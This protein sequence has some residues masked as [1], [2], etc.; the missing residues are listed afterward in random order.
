MG[1]LWQ[2]H[3]KQVIVRGRLPTSKAGA[4]LRWDFTRAG[5]ED[6]GLQRSLAL[7]VPGRAALG[8]PAGQVDGSKRLLW[9]VRPKLVQGGVQRLSIHTGTLSTAGGGMGLPRTAREAVSVE[10]RVKASSRNQGLSIG[11]R[12]LRKFF[13][14]CRCGGGTKQHS[15]QAT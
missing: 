5:S 6:T 8:A 15:K 11:R 3:L 4:L 7:P 10:G 2:R 9:C 1:R 12:D 13:R 14:Y